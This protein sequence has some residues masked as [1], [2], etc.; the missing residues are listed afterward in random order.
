MLQGFQNQALWL[1]LYLG[2][3]CAASGD[4]CKAK[5]RNKHRV[6]FQQRGEGGIVLGP[7]IAWAKDH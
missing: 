1:K 2:K 7:F 3:F 4:V 5:G 6:E